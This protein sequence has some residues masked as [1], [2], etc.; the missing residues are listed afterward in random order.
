MSQESYIWEVSIIY[1]TYIKCIVWCILPFSAFVLDVVSIE[2]SWL[3]KY[4]PQ[5]CTFSKP[6]EDPKPTYDPT[7]DCIKCTVH[8]TYGSHNW[9]LPDT[10]IE[11][12]DGMDKYRWFGRF[13]L[14]GKIVDY[15]GANVKHLLCQPYVMLK[16]WSKL[17]KCTQSLLG[18]LVSGKICTRKA[19]IERWT[20]DPKCEWF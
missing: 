20:N 13:L 7:E 18:S 1:Y 2:P 12:P 4:A 5:M 11:Y 19:L 8:C 15:F 17:K 3:A 10:E 9:L 6:L 14:E 16:S